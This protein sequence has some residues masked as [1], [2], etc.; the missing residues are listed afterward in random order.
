[1]IPVIPIAIAGVVG[2]AGALLLSPHSGRENR[3]IAAD[4]LK[5]NEARSFISERVAGIRGK[6]GDIAQG[7]GEPLE[8]ET[9]KSP[10]DGGSESDAGDS[11][12]E[13]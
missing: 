10:E 4:K 12:N 3:E 9:G 1:M 6:G 13:A 5:V 8:A 11:E 7:E 2:A